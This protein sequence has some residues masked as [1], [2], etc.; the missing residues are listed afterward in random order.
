MDSKTLAQNN[1]AEGKKVY[2]AYD[3]K[4]YDVTDS[5]KWK[6]GKHMMRHSAGQDL[7]VEMSAAPHGPEVFEKFQQLDDLEKVQ[8]D[9]GPEAFWPLN[10]IYEKFPIVKRHSHPVSVHYPVAFLM[11]SFL[12]CLLYLLTKNPAF[13]STAFHMLVFGVVTAPVAMITGVQSWWLYYGLKYSA[14]IKSKLLIAPA[15]VAIGGTATAMH[16]GNPGILIDGGA[17]AFTYLILVG[18]CTPMAGLLGFIGGQMTF[19]D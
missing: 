7:T 10:M 19:P 8:G 11:G 9:K 1:G 15:M 17:G 13:E 16:I 6:T 5:P 14:R 2:V 4:V 12:F 18:V 3:G